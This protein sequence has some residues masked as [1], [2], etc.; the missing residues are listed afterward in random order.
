MQQIESGVSQTLDAICSELMA[1]RELGGRRVI[2]FPKVWYG[3]VQLPLDDPQVIE[4]K[5]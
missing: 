3:L 5:Q 4:S 1:K 2:F